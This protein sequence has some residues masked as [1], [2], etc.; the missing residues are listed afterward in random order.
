LEPTHY[1]YYY[2]CTW[3]PL[4]ST[5]TTTTTTLGAHYYYYTWS[6]T[7]RV[8]D[9]LLPGEGDD[10]VFGTVL[11]DWILGKYLVVGF[12]VRGK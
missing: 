8:L 11:L 5:T 9:V 2:Y 10:S 1:Y 6:P 7:H 4:T 3:S 12:Q